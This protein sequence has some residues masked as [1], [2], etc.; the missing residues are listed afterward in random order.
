[1]YTKFRTFDDGQYF[2]VRATNLQGDQ[3]FVVDDVRIALDIKNMDVILSTLDEND[4]LKFSIDGVTFVDIVNVFGLYAI[5]KVSS[6]PNAKAFRKW[7]HSIIEVLRN[8][9]DVSSVNVSINEIDSKE[10]LMKENES[11]KEENK[12][13][14]M[15]LNLLQRFVSVGDYNV[16]YNM[17]WN[18]EEGLMVRD[19][20][21]AFC[22]SQFIETRKDPTSGENCYPL[23]AWESWL[24][25]QY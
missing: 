17:G 5:V 10:A 7:V 12:I 25:L 19:E 11:L 24:T 22:K 8:E 16:E 23:T 4:H 1:M 21:S 2:K 3:W 6:K 15:S 9:D 13:L 20:M 14:K 18:H